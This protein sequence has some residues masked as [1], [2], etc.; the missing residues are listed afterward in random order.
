MLSKEAIIRALNN[1]EIDISVAFRIQDGIPTLYE[2]EQDILSSPLKDNLYSDRLK[3]TMGP[4]IKILVLVRKW[5]GKAN[6][7][8]L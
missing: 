2:T 1:K 5:V 4:I 8:V 6:K 7:S 3:L